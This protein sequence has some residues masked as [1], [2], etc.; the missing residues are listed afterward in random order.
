M[1]PGSGKFTTGGTRG[2]D[3]PQSTRRARRRRQRKREKRR[4]ER[5]KRR[6]EREK[7]REEREKRDIISI[8]FSIPLCLPLRALRVLCGESLPLVS[9]RPGSPPAGYS[10]IVNNWHML[11]RTTFRP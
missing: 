1:V 4:E 10:A 3:S 5:E 11:S 6:E 9:S 8:L 2:R 7:R